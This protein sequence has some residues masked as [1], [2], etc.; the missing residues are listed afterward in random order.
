MTIVEQPIWV[1]RLP[2]I[3]PPFTVDQRERD[4]CMMLPIN[5]R[6]RVVRQVFPRHNVRDCC[7]FHR[8]EDERDT[9]MLL[10]TEDCS[11]RIWRPA[12]LR[13]RTY[14]DGRHRARALIDAG[15]HRIPATVTDD[16][17]LED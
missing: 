9:A 10:L 8:H 16:R 4:G 2:Q 12:G 13:R 11:I 15:V 6:Q 3:G 5:W 7:N 17:R 14:Q 1:M